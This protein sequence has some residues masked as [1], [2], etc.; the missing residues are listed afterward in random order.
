MGLIYK[1]I[2]IS[3]L[4]QPYN[5]TLNLKGD[6][7]FLVL[8]ENFIQK[9]DFENDVEWTILVFCFD[10]KQSNVLPPLP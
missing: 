1:D 6:I 10:E 7:N 3:C 5:L 4:Y 8:Q 9:V 2:Y